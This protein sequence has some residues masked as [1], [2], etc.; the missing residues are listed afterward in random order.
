MYRKLQILHSTKLL[1]FTGLLAKCRKNCRGFVKSQYTF[2]RAIKISRENFRVLSKTTKVL[3]HGGF[4]VDGNSP[5]D[6]QSIYKRSLLDNY[7]SISHDTYLSPC[8]VVEIHQN[9]EPIM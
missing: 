1:Q 6:H 8:F 3:Y 9:G 7:Y 5:T 4:V 2:K